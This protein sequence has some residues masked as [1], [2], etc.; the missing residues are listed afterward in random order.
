M[1]R[2]RKSEEEVQEDIPVAKRLNKLSIGISA[3][4]ST[5]PKNSQSS[6]AAA[7]INH[8]T[9]NGMPSG[10]CADSETCWRTVDSLHA[11]PDMGG[12][13]QLHPQS[14]R[15]CESDLESSS[16]WFNSES[17]PLRVTDG[18]CGVCPIDDSE[19]EQLRRSFIH[20]LGAPILSRPP[21]RDTP[22]HIPAIA[23]LPGD[24]ISSDDPSV[25]Y[26]DPEMTEE[27][28]PHYF[29]VNRLLFEMHRDRLGR[30]Q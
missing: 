29:R 18:P 9:A 22:W 27:S 5:W 2:K 3:S 1:A 14:L 24:G 21:L 13:P 6:M 7:N 28:N 25:G 17:L 11:G 10:C 30:L 15:T 19:E 23:S 8:C 4:S 26:Y 12:G 16:S 20:A